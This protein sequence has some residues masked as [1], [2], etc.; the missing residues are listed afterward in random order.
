MQYLS[1]GKLT[2]FFK[3]RV[4][5]QIQNLKIIPEEWL[6]DSGNG[7]GSNYEFLQT[8]RVTSYIPLRS[9][10]GNGKTWTNTRL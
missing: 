2:F 4:D 3:E 10:M 5:S 8:L 1:N 6:A 9:K 7:H